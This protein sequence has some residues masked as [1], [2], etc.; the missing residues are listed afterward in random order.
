MSM[1]C[2]ETLAASVIDDRRAGRTQAAAGI[3]RAAR[4]ANLDLAAGQVVQ[5]DCIDR[6]AVR[7]RR[8]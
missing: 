3:I 1:S 4:R 2:S 6:S 5:Q 8:H 7:A